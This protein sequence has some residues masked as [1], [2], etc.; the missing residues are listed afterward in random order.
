MKKIFGSFLSL[1]LILVACTSLQQTGTP[2]ASSTTSDTSWSDR[3]IFKNGLV[4][5]QRSVLKDLKGASVY[6]LDFNIAA[7]LI[8]VSGH[9]EVQYTNTETVPLDKVELRLFP[10]ILG[11][12][13]DVSNITLNDDN[14]TPQYGLKNSLL[15]LPFA[16]PLQ[17]GQSVVLK[18]DFAVEVPQSL[19]V[20]YGVIAYADDVL[21][22]AHAY[23]MI[24]VYD[25]EGWNAEIPRNYGDI[26]YS[27]ASFY[28]AKITAPNDLTLV[29][30]GSD[31]THSEAGQD[32][33]LTVADGPARDFFLATSPKFR[34]VTQ[35]VGEVTIHS[36]A[37]PEQ[38]DAAEAAL[39]I[40]AQAVEDFSK[41]YAPYPYTELDV[42]GTPTL[43]GGIEY[44]GLVVIAER[45]YMSTN[46]PDTSARYLLDG[47]VAHEVGHQWFYNL[48]GDDQLDEPW[49]DEAFAQFLSLQYFK[50]KFGSGGEQGMLSSFQSRW[51]RVDD[52]NI[53]IGKP[54]AAY[55]EQEYSSIV[56]GRGPLFLVALRDKMGETVFDEFM[57]DYTAQL[58]WG[59][60]TPRFMQ[61]LAEKHCGCDLG[62][63]FKEWVSP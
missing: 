46:S 62:P 1:S 42:V 23:P 14:V 8:H 49:L 13:M 56:Y 12:K 63:L 30:S 19:E 58:S 29:T 47:V 61:S 25:D 31:V 5:S 11:G 51:D 60:A 18:M 41:R 10:N 17:P 4:P 36:Y 15:I 24:S 20:N 28:V 54:V 22:L 52:A 55:N 16:T 57:K 45:I 9:E 32:Q 43:A 7:D 44:P 21:A 48:V 33:V 40:A 39:K 34:E 3:S 53:P 35:K 6:H 59:I 37:K 26:T 2:T 50:D 38:K 27:D